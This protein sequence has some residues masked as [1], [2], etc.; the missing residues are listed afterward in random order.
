ME[1]EFKTYWNGLSEEDI[2]VLHLISFG[3]VF[4]ISDL[5]LAHVYLFQIWKQAATMEVS[6]RVPIL[7]IR[8]KLMIILKTRGRLV[9]KEK[10][11]KA[12]L[13]GSYDMFY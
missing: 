1:E 2:K 3:V 5:S 4:C 9:K 6:I 12:T 11:V 13:A 8:K 10:R 7:C